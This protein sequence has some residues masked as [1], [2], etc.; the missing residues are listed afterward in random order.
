MKVATSFVLLAVL[1]AS[2]AACAQ[3]NARPTSICELD[4]GGEQMNGR[5]VR[6]TVIYITDLLERSVLKDRRCQRR[7]ISPDWKEPL[8]S[9]LSAFEK[10]VYAL[11]DDTGSKQFLV[12]VSGT[13]VRQANENPHGTLIFEKIWSFK[14]V[15]GDWKKAK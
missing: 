1:L 12:D 10:A 6:L 15:R 9:S 4:R 14:R 3:S 5:H 11:A 2:G 13:F 8:D 7:Y